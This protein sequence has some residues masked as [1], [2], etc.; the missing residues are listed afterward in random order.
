MELERLLII[1]IV[2]NVVVIIAFAA[3]WI[4]QI[5]INKLSNELLRDILVAWKKYDTAV[6]ELSATVREAYLNLGEEIDKAKKDI[7]SDNKAAVF[8]VGLWNSILDFSK[9]KDVC[10]DNC[11]EKARWTKANWAEGNRP[12][13]KHARRSNAA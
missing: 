8:A 9:I 12:S 11:K 10:G 1:S 3:C 5:K 6:D 7:S 2:V 13:R 4:L